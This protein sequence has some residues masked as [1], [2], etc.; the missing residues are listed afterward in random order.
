MPP[1]NL[2]RERWLIE[3]EGKHLCECGCGQYVQP[4]ITR[5]YQ[6]RGLRF[7]PHHQS[8]GRFHGNY[9]RG[10]IKAKGYIW[11]LTQD[12][13]RRT[14]RNYVKRCWLVIEKALGRYLQPGEL[15]HHKNGNSLDDSLTNLEVSNP[16]T[17]GRLHCGGARNPAWRHDIDFDRD[18]RPRLERGMSRREICSILKC[19]FELLKKRQRLARLASDQPT[20]EK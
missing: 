14:K 17:H 10:W 7:C 13:P 2:E 4:T 3:N 15:V 9:K 6:N 20:I 19:S 16:V 5:Y 1:R 12:H 18:I 8:R 11:I